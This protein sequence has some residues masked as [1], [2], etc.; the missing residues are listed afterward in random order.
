MSAPQSLAEL[1]DRYVA[2]WAAHDPDAVV[3]LHSDQT[4]FWLHHGRPA[5]DG[6]TAVRDAFADMF[7]ALPDFG[8]VVHRTEFG[9]RHWVL[10]WTLTC[11]GPV[12]RPVRWDC[13]DLVTVTDDWRVARKDTFVDGVQFAA[14]LAG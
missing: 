11:S 6:R 4:R 5:V 3:A 1:Y 12:G 14:A 13:I 7:A 9:P 2:A 10:D 8:F